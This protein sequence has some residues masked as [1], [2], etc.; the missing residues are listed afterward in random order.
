MVGFGFWVGVS[1]GG[2]QDSGG[3]KFVQQ[4]G[5]GMIKMARKMQNWMM[6]SQVAKTGKNYK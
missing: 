6:E 5:W 3:T 2:K 1:P 4:I